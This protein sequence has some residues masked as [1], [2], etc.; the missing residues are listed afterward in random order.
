VSSIHRFDD[1]EWHVPTAPGTDPEAAAAAGRAGAARR[2]LAQGEGGFFTQVVR[3]PP[4][5]VAPVHSH[6][7][8]EVFMVLEGS[9]TFDG[10]SMGRFDLAVVEADQ[11][12]G[13]TAGPEG[14]SFLVVRQGPAAYSTSPEAGATS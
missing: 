2:F 8:S 1:A 13:F 3:M 14:L 11:P 7:H 9:C 10:E 12:Y 6:D 4:G 5:F